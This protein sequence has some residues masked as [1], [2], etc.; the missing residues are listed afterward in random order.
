MNEIKRDDFKNVF[1]S[2]FLQ[3]YLNK[4]RPLNSY[5]NSKNCKKHKQNEKQ[6]ETHIHFFYVPIIDPH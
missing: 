2:I 4:R 5:I 3:E 6:I 1:V